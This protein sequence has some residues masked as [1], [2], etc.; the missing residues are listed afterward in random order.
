GHHRGDTCSAGHLLAHRSDEDRDHLP[1][2]ADDRQQGQPGGSG[3]LLPRPALARAGQ[4]HPRRARHGSGRP[5]D[6]SE[7]RGDVGHP[8]PR[9]A[10]PPWSG[11]DLLDGVLELREPDAGRPDRRLAVRRR[12]AHHPHGQGRSGRDTGAVAD[13]QPQ[14][15]QGVLAR[16]RSQRPA[17]SPARPLRPRRGCADLPEGPGRPTDAA[18]VGVG[19]AARAPARDHRA[20]AGVGPLA[21]V[22]TLRRRGRARPRGV[23]AQR[24]PDE[25][26]TGPGV[27]GPDATDQPRARQDPGQRLPA[28]PQ[29]QAGQRHPRRPLHHGARRQARPTDPGVRARLEQ[30]GPRG[31]HAQRCRPG[32]APRRPAG[33]GQPDHRRVRRQAQRS[34]RRGRPGRRGGGQRRPGE[35]RRPSREAGDPARGPGAGDA[36]PGG[37]GRRPRRLHRRRGGADPAGAME[38]GA[39]PGRRG[40]GRAGRACP[41]SHRP[42]VAGSLAEELV[43][44]VAQV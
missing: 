4:G 8:R 10:H 19:R 27:G 13:P 39:G 24:R 33:P 28:H 43:G 31:D 3:L 26:L 36:R 16:V 5:G 1:A 11:L 15:R 23:H 7:H 18:G 38:C 37:R 6:A 44:W 42:E 25:P 40:R 29:G 34:A 30:A 22:A 2:G 20:T 32:R 17:L 9:D 35:A 21:A 41:A 12:G 14:P